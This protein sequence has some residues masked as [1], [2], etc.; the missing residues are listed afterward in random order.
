[1]RLV[2]R[3]L[4]AACAALSIAP[5]AAQQPTYPTKSIRFVVAFAPG[6]PGDVLARAMVPLLAER[7]RQPVVIENKPGGN[8]S[9]GIDLVAKAAPDGY[10]IGLG[11]SGAL[12]TNSSLYAKMP[13]NPVTDL[14]PVTSIAQFPFLLVAPPTLPAATLEEL[15]ALARAKPGEMLIGFGG[16]GT[17][18]HLA[19]ELFKLMAKV[20]M[21]N[22]PYKG[23]GAAA[24][25][26]A[27]GKLSLALV[28][29]QSALPHVKSGK[30]KALA[31]SS[32]KR[33]FAAPDAP[34]F[35]EAGL[36]GYEAGDWLGIVVPV[37][38]PGA[39]VARLNGDFV[40]ALKRA[41]VRDRII[42]A[43]AEPAPSTPVGFGAVIA[44]EVVKWSEVVQLS[45]ARGD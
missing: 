35:A 28:D 40:A 11:G 16:N 20:Q 42:A 34:T 9:E 8:G 27:N 36:P 44:A 1:M 19:A 25:D 10:T 32:A 21:V 33:V 45:G 41:E 14:A 6:E 29:V 18:T 43:G 31:V 38:T 23:D 13:Y 7:L 24:A 30:L 4:L 37:T 22:V 39:I 5:A 12:A 3:G 15:L 2:T 17:A 26:A